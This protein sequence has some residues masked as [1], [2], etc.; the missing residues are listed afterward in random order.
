MK[1]GTFVATTAGQARSGWSGYHVLTQTVSYMSSAQA[2]DASAAPFNAAQAEQTLQTLQQQLA[3][4]LTTLSPDQRRSMVKMAD[5]TSPFVQ[6]AFGYARNHPEFAPSYLNIGGIGDDLD[7]VQQLNS[8]IQP[9]AELCQQLSDSLMV[10]G[11]E[12]YQGALTYYNGVKQAAKQNQPGAQLVY[13]DLQTHFNKVR[14]T[15]KAPAS[16][17]KAAAAE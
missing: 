1:T 5:R 14:A 11:S 4:L 7:R 3:A 12:A 15:K 6:K 16:G 13:D 2:A 17:Q 9:I 10:A 8:L